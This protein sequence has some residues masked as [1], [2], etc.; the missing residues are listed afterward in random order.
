MNGTR[1]AQENHVTEIA[2]GGV[3]DWLWSVK[4]VKSL[5][6]SWR[7][8]EEDKKVQ[9][10]ARPPDDWAH[11]AAS[12]QQAFS[13]AYAVVSYLLGR[14]PMPMKAK[15]RLLPEGANYRDISVSHEERHAPIT[16]AF[17]YPPWASGGHH[18][19]VERFSALAT[20]VSRTVYEYQ[21]LYADAKPNVRQASS[22]T[23]RV[24]NDETRSGC[25]MD[26]TML[27]LTSGTHTAVRW[28]PSAAR[29]ALGGGADEQS[30]SLEKGRPAA[31][32]PTSPEGEGPRYADAVLWARY[33][34]AKSIANYLRRR[35]LPKPQATANNP[36]EMNAVLSVCRAMTQH[37]LDVS[38]TNGYPPSQVQFVPFF[39]AK[40][41]GYRPKSGA[42]G[43]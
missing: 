37:P 29:R 28:D 20:A 9:R 27:A 34:E 21:H 15:L 41:K 35:G 1:Q 24:I 38:A 13:R 12:W 40:L 30:L 6:P 4:A 8:W 11:P 25:W 16:L 43:Q 5:L 3:G 32:P 26:S 33:Y 36:A 14:R 10:R 22:K 18:A 2:S 42:N 7:A 39:P 23:N 19:T 17:Y 31:T